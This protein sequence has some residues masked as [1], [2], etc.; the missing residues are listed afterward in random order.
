MKPLN[1][2]WLE[3]TAEIIDAFP[4]I[5]L[6][7]TLQ[8][9]IIYANR[10]FRTRV[11][12]SQEEIREKNILNFFSDEGHKNVRNAMEKRKTGKECGEIRVQSKFNGEEARHYE[13]HLNP[14][15]KKGDLNALLFVIKDITKQTQL[16]K[17]NDKFTTLFSQS[18]IPVELFDAGG[19]LVD[20]NQSCK[21]LFGII[22][23]S[24]IVNEFNL[25]NDPNLPEN[26]KEDLKEKK[27]AEYKIEFDFGLV[28]DK[29]LY[30]TYKRGN[31]NLLIKI[32][33]VFTDHQITGYI[34]II[35]DTT[36]QDI[37]EHQLK[38]RMKELRCLYNVSTI[39]SNKKQKMEELLHI[40]VHEIVSSLQFPEIAVAQI[41]YNGK[42]FTTSHS[43]KRFNTVK[44]S[45]HIN[46]SHLEILVYYTQ[47]Q[48]F[49]TEEKELIHEIGL[50]IAL[51]LQEKSS[52]LKLKRKHEEQRIL[53]DNIPTQVWYLTDP[54]TYG[55]VNRAHAEFNGVKKQ[56]LAFK[57][58]YDLYPQGVAKICEVG[59]SE[60]FTTKEQIHKDEW[61]PNHSGERRL[62]SVTKIPKLDEE[63]EVE[64]VIC[65]AE[66]ITEKQRAKEELKRSEEYNRSIIELI[67]D[68]LI[69]TNSDG[70]YLDIITPSKE[71]LIEPKDSLLNKRIADVMPEEVAE[72]FLNCINKTVN[73]GKL[74]KIEY[75]LP[76]STG[77]FWF[78]ARIIPFD[79]EEVIA[80]IREIT[81]QK[82]AE[83]ALQKS[84]ELYKS[85]FLN[86]PV[87]III[88]DKE[89]GEIID[90]NPN[91]YSMFG[92]SSVK[93]LKEND[94]WCNPPYSFEDALRLIKKTD[95]EGPQETEW[96]SR[97]VTGEFFWEQIN[98]NPIY[99]NG[100]K[101]ILI[102]AI[103]ITERKRAENE[104]KKSKEKLEGIIGSITDHMSIMD[105][106]HTIVWV[107][108]VARK[109]FGTDL[110]GKKCYS[111]YHNKKKPCEP[112]VV[113][114]T[115]ADGKIH[116]HQTKVIDKNG[117]S[118][119]FWCTSNVVAKDREGNPSQVIEISRDIT[120]RKEVEKRLKRL[121]RLKSQFLRRTS[122]ELKTPLVSIKGYTNLL[123]EFHSDEVS[124]SVL[125]KL[126]EILG[127]CKR[128]ENLISDIL[129]TAKLSSGKMEISKE[130]I[131]LSSVIKTAIKAL[132]GGAISRKQKIE[133]DIDK[134][135]IVQGDKKK[136]LV[137]L[138][139][140]LS[141]AIKYTPKHGHISITSK[142]TPD[143]VVISIRDDGIGFTD[144]ERKNLFTQFGKIERYGEGLDVDIEGS[145]LGLFI[146]K[147]IIDLHDGTI[148]VESE[149]RNKGSTFSFS[150]P[151]YNVGNRDMKVTGE[152]Q[153]S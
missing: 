121:N 137:V 61:V 139:N 146:S 64:Y 86:S 141:N 37:R 88:H 17:M 100:K 39:L 143:N 42:V 127:G 59:N 119:H 32:S 57:N 126:Y 112:C 46:D 140:I 52:R 73:S 130:V 92:F 69:K 60:V 90:A 21:E 106:H 1:N 67:P 108:D 29:N 111:V 72:P 144:E 50:K 93:E 23:P 98:T 77:E 53:L 103:D 43:P 134:N 49:L 54:V 38:E 95:E 85:L 94:F 102:S 129:D 80:L 24:E 25:F 12:L 128:L 87:S 74:Q 34:G 45:F 44:K 99:I 58:I 6:I 152:K 13:L 31:I 118:L 131:D 18:P 96:L 36:E 28:E 105:K 65:S 5:T 14:L 91:A 66:D 55:A 147:K 124:D 63:G 115:F 78:E 79:Q 20:L 4:D 145:G 48:D 116:N 15:E 82:Q 125:E 97:K 120:H 83:K 149:G 56:D 109:I 47:E 113:T 27:S 2:I 8:G 7:C 30:R 153:I 33:P 101:R 11:G 110:V 122:H 117:H 148:W 41:N 123:L 114:K 135:L 142:K 22:D 16:K 3:G 19:K 138:E 132:K 35:I 136:M 76:L 89:T 107:N 84:E 10:A 51:Y 104:L 150:I 40:I 133:M 68:L 75:K 70:V 151:A 9:D 62:L 71:Y 26:L 81:E